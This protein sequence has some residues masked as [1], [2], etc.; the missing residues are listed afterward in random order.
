MA[1][2]AGQWT[3]RPLCSPRRPPLASPVPPHARAAV[4]GGSCAHASPV[5]GGT[6]E[7]ELENEDIVEDEVED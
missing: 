5:A 2:A 3:R 7:D 6:N 4:A 1:N